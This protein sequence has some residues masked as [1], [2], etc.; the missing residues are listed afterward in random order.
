MESHGVAFALWLM[1]GAPAGWICD[2]GVGTGTEQG[3]MPDQ[4]VS[5]V[6]TQDNVEGFFFQTIRPLQRLLPGSAQGWLLCLRL[7]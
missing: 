6:H 1:M 5:V 4:S 3:Q 2:L 7:L